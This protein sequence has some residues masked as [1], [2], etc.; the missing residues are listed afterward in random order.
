MRQVGVSYLSHFYFMKTLQKISLF[1]L[2]L[3]SLNIAFSQE[4]SQLE[5]EIINQKINVYKLTPTLLQSQNNSAII[6][7]VGNQNIN[8]NTILANHSIIQVYQN[9]DFN[10]THIYRVEAN[11]NEF[12]IQDG[13]QNSIHELSIGNYNTIE[14]QYIQNGN[15]N[16]ITSFGSNSISENLKIQINGNNASVIIINR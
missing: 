15:N 4:N 6:T 10:T 12:I 5:L 2:L 7:Q 14:N 13:N 16:R 11:V 9:G 8:Q 3:I 1:L